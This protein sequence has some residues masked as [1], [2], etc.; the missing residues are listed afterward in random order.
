MKTEAPNPP[1]YPVPGPNT[2]DKSRFHNNRIY[3]NKE[4]YFDGVSESVWNY[5]VGGY[6]VAEKW[7]KDRKG[8][9]LTYDELTHYRHVIAAIAKT[10][11][12]Q[13]QIDAAIPSWPLP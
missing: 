5:H 7:L 6:Q 3:I 9:P 1:G 4:Q 10:I 2:V 8:R 12:I 11:Y 13:T